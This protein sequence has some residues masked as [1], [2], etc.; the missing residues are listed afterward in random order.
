[1]LAYVMKLLTT[2]TERKAAIHA[3]IGLREAF[4]AGMW[5]NDFVYRLAADI[6]ALL[7][8][9]SVIEP[10]SELGRAAERQRHDWG[11]LYRHGVGGCTCANNDCAR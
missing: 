11:C 1:M 9:P 4:K 7:K 10:D 6:E 3:A 5:E 8:G 2:E